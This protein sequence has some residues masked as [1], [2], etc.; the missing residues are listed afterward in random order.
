MTTSQT[1]SVWTPFN[2]DSALSQR[3]LG[4]FSG[5]LSTKVYQVVISEFMKREAA[6]FS[7]AKLA[8]RIHK[9]P[10]VI[11]RLFSGPGNWTMDTVSAVMLGLG[12]ELEVSAVPIQAL[13]TTESTQAEVELLPD[14]PKSNNAPQG[15]SAQELR[16]AA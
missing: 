7:K 11:T 13:Q 10:E 16:I 8:R 14:S 2:E 4:Y 6:G 3:E 5:R 1:I 15:S 12:F 9:S